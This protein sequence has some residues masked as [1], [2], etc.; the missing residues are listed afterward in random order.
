[1]DVFDLIT[2]ERGYEK[3]DPNDPN[4]FFNDGYD[5]YGY[6]FKCGACGLERFLLG[7]EAKN[8]NGNLYCKKCNTRLGKGDRLP[9]RRAVHLSNIMRRETKVD[10]KTKL[11]YI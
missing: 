6:R 5:H 1:M 2:R 10:K 3:V 11:K 4:M 7:L 8:W 9:E